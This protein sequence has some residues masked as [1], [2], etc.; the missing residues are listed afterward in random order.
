MNI[1]RANMLPYSQV[2]DLTTYLVKEKDYIPWHASLK[3]LT[4]VNDML[5]SS[6]TY[7]K[8]EVRYFNDGINVNEPLSIHVYS[9]GIYDIFDRP[10]IQFCWLRREREYGSST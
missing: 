1:A 5:Y 8:W 10:S 7:G 9:I 3:A 4:Y 2:L 6:E